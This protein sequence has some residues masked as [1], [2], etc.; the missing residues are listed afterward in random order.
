MLTCS[1]LFDQDV[2]IVR[3]RLTESHQPALPASPA[4]PASPASSF[5]AFNLSFGLKSISQN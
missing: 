3:T 4:G 1:V 2:T 5:I